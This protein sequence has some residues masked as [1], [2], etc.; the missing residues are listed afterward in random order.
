MYN[1]QPDSR[2]SNEAGTVTSGAQP[3]IS[4]EVFC[5]TASRQGNLPLPWRFGVQPHRAFTMIELVVVI[6]II[7]ILAALAIPA[8][9]AYIEKAKQKRC[10]V[11]IRGIEKAI[12]AF[13][14]ER[15]ALPDTLAEV[16]FGTTLDP[17][18]SLYQYLRIEGSGMAGKG[19]L[20]KDRH[21]NPLNSDYDLYS[22]GKDRDSK[23][24]LMNPASKDDIIRANNGAYVGLAENF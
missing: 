21:M 20:R 24:P 19:K 5:A 8:Y 1:V 10:I 13:E 16:G 2:F 12:A 6:A 14:N 18:G 7:A 11:E 17:W 4:D 22:M 9:S 23:L 15:S 3:E